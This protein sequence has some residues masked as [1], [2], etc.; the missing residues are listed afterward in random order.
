[1]LSMSED[2]GPEAQTRNNVTERISQAQAVTE[3]TAQ[4]L[5]RFLETT[6][7]VRRIRGSQVASGVLGAMGFALFIL[8]V[9]RA[10]EDL[11]LVS[12]PYGAMAIGLVL[13]ALT[14]LLLSK[15]SGREG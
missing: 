6:E 12:N 4:K 11:P 5:L 15:L 1:M 3:E 10:S 8:G 2:G 13:L 9:E 14:G 7:P